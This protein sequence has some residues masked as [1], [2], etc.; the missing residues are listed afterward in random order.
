MR[1]G[2]EVQ[3]HILV[4]Q[5][6]DTVIGNQSVAIHPMGQHHP[7][8]GPCGAGSVED[9][10]QIVQLQLSGPP[11]QLRVILQPVRQLQE[12]LEIDRHGVLRTL[13]HG[14]VEDNQLL[15]RGAMWHTAQGRVVL[16][17]L[18][19]KKVAHLGV[20][21]HVDHLALR[22]GGIKGNRHRTYAIRPEIHI[23][24][25]RLVLREHGQIL[26]YPDPQRQQRTGNLPHVIR[27]L[28]PRDRYPC[29]LFIVAVT[30]GR[31]LTI[32]LRL[33]VNQSRERSRIQ[34]SF[35]F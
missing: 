16:V 34:H 1:E 26:L 7:F 4:T 24:A 29:I 5:G 12:F 13:H 28:V 33:N 31:P 23:Q 20:V 19:D 22:T 14:G 10:G 2:Q 27:K 6:K 8:A 9:V 21:H 32:A 15:Q 3:G 35:D 11:F 25:F 18:P 30:H 17:L